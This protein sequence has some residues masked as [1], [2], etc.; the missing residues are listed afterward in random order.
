MKQSGSVGPKLGY[1]QN[2]KRSNQFSL[3]M[4]HFFVFDSFVTFV[5]CGCDLK[6]N[7]NKIENEQL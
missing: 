6:D 3:V 2:G 1:A 5:G 7:E 4:E